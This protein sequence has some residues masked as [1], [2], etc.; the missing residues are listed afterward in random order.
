MQVLSHSLP[1]L[2][3]MNNLSYL[4]RVCQVY[5]SALGTIK[6]VRVPRLIVTALCVVA[7]AWDLV[8]GRLGLQG[9]VSQFQA[10]QDYSVTAYF[11]NRKRVRTREEGRKK[12]YGR[13]EE[14]KEG[15][16]EGK[17]KSRTKDTHF[18]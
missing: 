18:I 7:H 4:R 17:K 8:R 3:F 10:S 14:R 6:S 9:R 16:K 11:K 5:K 12:E 15:K 2:Y 1:S 13:K